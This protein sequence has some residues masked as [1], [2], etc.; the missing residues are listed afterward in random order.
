VIGVE[1]GGEVGGVRDINEARLSLT[2]ALTKISPSIDIQTESI[3]IQDKSEECTPEQIREC[4][5]DVKEHPCVRAKWLS[6]GTWRRSE[7]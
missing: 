2:H 3:Q 6:Q 4:H 5:R 7:G 1:E